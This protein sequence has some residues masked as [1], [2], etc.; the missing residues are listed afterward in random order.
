MVKV[1]RIS[2]KGSIWET[3]QLDGL[4]L[5]VYEVGKVY[6]QKFIG[7]NIQMANKYVK[8]TC[9]TLL[10]VKGNAYSNNNEILD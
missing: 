3:E 10:V 2:L 6:E 4:W 8:K 9:S 1:E 5:G 7:E